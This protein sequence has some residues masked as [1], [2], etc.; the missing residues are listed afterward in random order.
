MLFLIFFI[1]YEFLNFNF[2]KVCFLKFFFFL[3]LIM[4]ETNDNN[5][6]IFEKKFLSLKKKISEKKITK[7]FTILQKFDYEDLE[8]I[9]FEF[10][11]EKI[12]DFK[13]LKK[14]ENF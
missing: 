6:L 1:F 5:S 2:S 14:M 10:K 8:K 12:E 13:N 7:I 11:I 4:L 9:F 3:I